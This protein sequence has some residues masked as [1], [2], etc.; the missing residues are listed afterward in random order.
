MA[1]GMKKKWGFVTALLLLASVCALVVTFRGVLAETPTAPPGAGQPMPVKVTVVEKKPL[2]IWTSYSGRMEAVDYV[3]LRPEVSGRIDEIKFEDGQVVNKGDILFVIDP[4]PYEA[5]VK[6]AQAALSSAKNQQ[7]LATKEFKRAEEL[8]KTDAVPK[9]VYD[10]RKNAASIARHSIEAAQAQL[11]R[12]QVDLDHAH[13]KAPISGRI[14]RPEITVGNVVDAGPNAPV[15]AS[16]VSNEGIYADF[17][18]DEQTYLRN[19]RA[20]AS[21]K[22]AESQIP[23]RLSLS[24][25]DPVVYEGTIKS[26]DN[27]INTASGTIRARAYFDNQDGALIPGMYA[28]I[29][30]GSPS[31]EEVVLL[32]DQAISTDQDRKFVYVIGEGNKVAYREIKLGASVDGKHVITSGLE[33]GEQ[34]ITE[35]IMK[36]RPDMPVAPQVQ[37]APPEPASVEPAA[38]P[39]EEAP[40]ENLLTPEEETTGLQEEAPAEP[41][42]H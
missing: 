32:T 1:Q 40:V 6:E 42:Q 28:S 15:L 21:S 2:R 10:E 16:I 12:A 30:M 24:N 38:A 34:V 31:V 14:S 37:E 23:V 20:Q 35:G 5:S 22:E 26:F 25:G 11:A 9:K 33:P 29:S 19:V 3:E 36:L 27:R 17:E 8:L 18:V 39:A 41:E 7:E 4:R 13:I